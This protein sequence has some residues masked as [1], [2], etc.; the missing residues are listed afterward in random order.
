[1]QPLTNE[2]IHEADLDATIN[3]RAQAVKKFQESRAINKQRL[4]PGPLNQFWEGPPCIYNTIEQ[5]W[6][7]QKTLNTWPSPPVPYE[8]TYEMPNLIQ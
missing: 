4:L 6:E 1:M 5:N 8:I 7:E 3:R 2:Q